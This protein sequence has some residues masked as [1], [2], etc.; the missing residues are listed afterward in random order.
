MIVSMSVA[1][2]I[3][4]S[5]GNVGSTWFGFGLGSGLGIG[6]GRFRVQFRSRSA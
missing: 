2:K 6:V 1:E 3:R 5:G 4:F